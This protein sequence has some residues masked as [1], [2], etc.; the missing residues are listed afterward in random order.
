MTFLR[1]NLILIA[2]LSLIVPPD[3]F[4]EKINLNKEINL[5]ELSQKYQ[6]CKND[7]YR[8]DCYDFDR[9][10]TITQ[11]GY[12]KKNRL[13]EGIV[14]DETINKITF[15]FIDGIEMPLSGCVKNISGWYKCKY[16]DKYKPIRNG[17][18]DQLGNKQGEFIY[19]WKSGTTYEGYFK[20]DEKHGYGKLTSSDGSIFEGNFKD[21]V[22]HGYGKMTW[23]DDATYEGNYKDNVK[24]GYGKM[25]WADGATY[26][27]NWYQGEMVEK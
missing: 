7:L 1:K 17:R 4:A 15:K 2:F 9:G 5:F 25:T 16:G 8:D 11:E 13:W 23:A 10:K 12:W 20:D 21:D 22:K 3:L 18:F 26:E 6:R 27:G 24:H 14:R 19:I